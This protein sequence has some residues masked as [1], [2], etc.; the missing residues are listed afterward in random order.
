[1]TET[2]E[3]KE[4]QKP[5]FRLKLGRQNPEKPSKHHGTSIKWSV[6]I[7]LT[8]FSVIILLV[9]WLCQVVFLD[10][11]YKKI[12][13]I[14]IEDAAGRIVDNIDS[15]TLEDYAQSL[16]YR[17]ELCVL[18]LRMADEDTGYSVVSVHTQSNC[19]I[20]NTDKESK[21]V[22]YDSAVKN[23]GRLLQRFRYDSDTRSYYSVDDD[24]YKS[25]TD[26]PESIIYSIITENADGESMFIILNSIISPVSATIRT[27]FIMLTYISALL[28]LMT[29]ALAL[30]ISRQISKPIV[31]LNEAAKKLATRNYEPNFPETGYKE[32]A[33]LGE[34]LNYAARELSKVDDLCRELIAN[35]SHDLRTPLTMITGYSEVMRDLPGEN[36]PENIQIVIDEANRL[37]TLVNDVLD[38]SRFRAGQQKFDPEPFCLT[39]AVNDAVGRYG[40]LI[41]RDG[42]KIDFIAE[43][44]ELWVNSDETRIIQVLYNLIN[45]AITYTGTDKRV[46]VRQR[47][48][49]GRAR[50]EVTDTGEG[51]PEDKLD[52]IWERYYKV[53]SVHKR[54]A[55]GTGLGLS[56][57]KQLI[58]M[59]GGKCGVRSM[60]G[61]GSTFWFELDAIE[62][63][64]ESGGENPVEL[65]EDDM[66]SPPSLPEPQSGLSEDKQ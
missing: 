43:D 33:E 42:Y 12:K 27:L 25:R 37:T 56:I 66:Q 55:V 15:E 41:S 3:S 8:L 1:M 20:H 45:N 22:L 32:V 47:L 26:D 39:K 53:D 21:F 44:G 63:P 29:L 60:P 40:K 9:L 23:G 2:K 31:S 59:A 14:E 38:I 5:T 11:I 57:V 17:N 4:P 51:I 34:T 49:E 62:K 52:V 10:A 65:T 50:V 35:I 54:A 6:Y 13:I 64:E 16:A 48:L 28:L 30:I 36:T 24:L 19:A 7:A 18:I 61:W 46:L 58:D